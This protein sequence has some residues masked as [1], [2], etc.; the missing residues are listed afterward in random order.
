MQSQLLGKKE[1]DFFQIHL[2][3]KK[4]LENDL[5]AFKIS[6]KHV[7]TRRKHIDQPTSFGAYYQVSLG[8]LHGNRVRA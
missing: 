1:A 2:I 6:T 4:Q 5:T 3:T 8:I 7:A